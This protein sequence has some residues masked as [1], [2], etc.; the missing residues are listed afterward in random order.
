MSAPTKEVLDSLLRT[1]GRLGPVNND[2]L[3][4]PKGNGGIRP[5]GGVL[6]K[7]SAATAPE[8]LELVVA[9]TRSNAARRD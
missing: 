3:S 6:G 4:S 1:A 2:L 8:F 5:L 7:A 9:V